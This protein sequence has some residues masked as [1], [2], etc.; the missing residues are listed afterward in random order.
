M[1]YNRYRGNS[2]RVERVEDRPAPPREHPSPP[3]PPPPTG[4]PPL[5]EPPGPPPPPPPRP[6]RPPKLSG[7]IG[8]LLRSLS[9]IRLETEDLLL[10]AILYLLYRETKD[11]EFLIMM[12]GIVLF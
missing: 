1:A 3:P 2:G 5:P 10:L 8:A 7:E 4:P 9:E 11:E 6:P 12:A